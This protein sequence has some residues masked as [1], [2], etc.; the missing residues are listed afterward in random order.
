MDHIG[1]FG[2]LMLTDH[3]F[4]LRQ[5]LCGSRVCTTL[6][7]T[8]LGVHYNYYSPTSRP[9]IRPTSSPLH[10]SASS[11]AQICARLCPVDSKCPFNSRCACNISLILTAQVLRAL[12]LASCVV[13][14]HQPTDQQPLLL[15]DYLRILH[16]SLR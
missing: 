11:F 6:F 16:P 7:T 9:T 14:F 1:W 4:V 3:N 5:L 10:S 12:P 2:C 13:I 15:I 8:L